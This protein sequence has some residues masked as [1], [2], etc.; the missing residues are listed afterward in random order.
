[1]C[2]IAG[3]YRR[4]N[5]R[6]EEA[7][8][9]AQCDTIRHRGPDDSGVFSDGDFGFGM[10]RLSIIDLPGGHQPIVSDDGRTLITFNGEIYNHPALRRELEAAGRRFHTN[11]D[12][13]TILVAYQHWGDEAWA[14]LEG[15]FA[16]AIW[17]RQTRTLRLA[18]DPLGIKPLYIA[19]QAGGIAFASELK[20]LRVLP[21]LSFEVDPRA[22]HDF[23]S[24]GHVRTPRTI[25]RG[26]RTLPPGHL[27]TIGATGEAEERPFWVPRFQTQHGRSDEDWIAEF[28]DRWLATVEAHML[29]D[30]D[31]GV[32]LSGGVDSSAVAAAMKRVSSQ[33]VKAFTIGFPVARYDE[34]P[35]AAAVAK[36]LGCEHIT[37][38]VDLRAATDILPAIQRC[39]DEPFADPAAVPTW[40]VSQMAAEHVKVVLSGEGGDELFAGYKRHRNEARMSRYRGLLR[41]ADPIGRWIDAMPPTPWRGTNYLR[42]RLQR[43][44]NAAL[45]PD[46]ITRFFAKTQITSPELRAS[47][48]A[49]DFHERMD[50]PGGYER[51]RDE[52]FGDPRAISNDPLEQFIFADLTLNLPS[53]MLTKVDRASMA[54]SLE[55]RVPFLGHGLVDWALTVP[56]DLKLRGKTGKYIVR[57]AIEP[58]LPE[59]ILDRRKQGFQMPL[60]EWFAGDF[61]AY[62]RSLWRDSGAASSGFLDPR[63]V[64]SL[65]DEHRA[66]TRNHGRLLYALSMFALWWDQ[67]RR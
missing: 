67:Q 42:Q 5:R 43:F 11:S 27:L 16:V 14:R 2:G 37:R 64:E 66:G 50:L 60:S 48:Y 31:V 20:A 44:R 9:T 29:A 30:V 52:Y 35:Y 62:S 6:V 13:E 34:T 23:F 25:Y 33:P 46:G 21:D 24:F 4:G 28:R 17:D 18:R 39:Y 51:L 57:K 3:W 12:T 61:G 15:M 26:V 1:M 49:P 59:G 10:R 58:W 40:Y 65:F 56:L 19:A 45:L 47:L 36:H 55:A 7:L 38:V 32:F 8:L 41:A 53:A 63:A 22:A 54:H